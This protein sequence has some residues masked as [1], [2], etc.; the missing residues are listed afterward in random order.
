[1]RSIAVLLLAAVAACGA[2][3]RRQ[4]AWPDAPM[5]L[6]DESDREQAIDQLWVLPLGPERDA[7]RTAITNAIVA[8]ITDALEEDKPYVAQGLLFQLASLWLLDPAK[9]SEGLAPHTEM[10]HKL[11]A[12]F[13]KSGALE[14][15]IA[16]LVLLS[17]V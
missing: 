13:A 7:T 10:L 12:T 16:T 1:M 15:T 17:E 5:Q 11:R 2:G 8:R 4:P 6:R 14:P 9:V 3:A